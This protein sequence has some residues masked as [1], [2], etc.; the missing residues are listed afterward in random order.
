MVLG[1]AVLALALA[2][3]GGARNLTRPTSTIVAISLFFA[4]MLLGMPSAGYAG[5]IPGVA[6]RLSVYVVGIAA[7]IERGL[8]LSVLNDKHPEK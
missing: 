1:M 2:R 3:L 6:T 7:L 4:F 8:L 5:S